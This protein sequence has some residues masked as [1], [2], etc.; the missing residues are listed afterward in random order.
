VS[1]STP[2]LRPPACRRSTAWRRRV[3][4]PTRN[5]LEAPQ[6][7]DARAGKRSSAPI[8]SR[9]RRLVRHFARAGQLGARSGAAC[10]RSRRLQPYHAKRGRCARRSRQRLT[11][12]LEPCRIFAAEQVLAAHRR[13][14]PAAT[15]HLLED[16]HTP[17]LGAAGIAKN[18]LKLSIFQRRRWPTGKSSTAKAPG[19]DRAGSHS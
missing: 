14:A 19:E 7:R 1:S 9:S 15:L 10:V 2:F 11:Q 13:N 5:A 4:A 17:V 18:G 8:L 3:P 12:S 6:R 16:A